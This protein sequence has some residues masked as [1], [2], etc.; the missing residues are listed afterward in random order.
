MLT[1]KTYKVSKLEIPIFLV[2]GDKNM[3][4]DKYCKVHFQYVHLNTL[5]HA[6]LEKSPDIK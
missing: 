5:I 1:I 2:H 6:I 3:G 4:V